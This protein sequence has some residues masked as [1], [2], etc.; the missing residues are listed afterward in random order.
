MN[1]SFAYLAALAAIASQA[2]A[3]KCYA[4]AFS[5]GDQTSAYQVGVLKGLVE[6]SAPGETSYSA[7]S[8]VSG[9]AVNAVI[10]ASFPVGQEA[11]AVERMQSFWDNS[12]NTKLWKDWAGG[13]AEGLLVKGG[14]YNNKPLL[15]FLTTEMAD[16]FPNQRFV[17]VGLTDVL[18]GQYQD[19]YAGDLV[20]SELAQVMLGSFDYAGFF[21]PEAA[22]GAEWFDGST[23]WDI[24][25]FSAVNKCLETHL[26]EDVV[27]DVVMT[28]SR[29]LKQ[30]DASNYK[31]I[32]MLWRFLHVTRYY[33]TMDGLLRAQFAYPTINFRHI[34]APSGDL[35]DTR[36]PLVSHLN[37]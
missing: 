10:M 30:V 23:V 28:N 8:G 19:F 13:L 22:L 36:L 33:N 37:L 6:Q 14:L 16:I 29:N 34:I 9:G 4:I 25:I 35:P 31:S 15:N 3:D 18:T 26:P 24:D 21:A 20:G 1:K 27:V 17:D 32:D 5:S 2:Y 12:A 7:V 11:A